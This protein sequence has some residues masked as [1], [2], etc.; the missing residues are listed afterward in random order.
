MSSIGKDRDRTKK[1]NL[2]LIE[3]DILKCRNQLLELE[4]FYLGQCRS[5]DQKRLSIE[6]RLFDLYREKRVEES[7]CWRDKLW[8]ERDLVNLLREYLEIERRKNLINEIM[9]GD[10]TTNQNHD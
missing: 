9:E 7:S 10:Y 5:A 1:E 2:Y 6:Q 3:S 4:G 8:L